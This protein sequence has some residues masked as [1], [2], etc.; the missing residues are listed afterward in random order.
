MHSTKEPLTLC[1]LA[2]L[3]ALASAA[4]IRAAE[5]E[6]LSNLKLPDT[7]V[8]VAQPV[9]GGTF[10]PP[11]GSPLNDLPAFCRVAGVI[12]PTSD[13]HIQFEVWLPMKGWNSKYRGVGNGGFAGQIPYE[14]LADSVRRNYASAGTDDG[15]EA[16]GLDGS[17]A[18]HHPE[19][20]VDFGYRAV[21]LTAQN[22]K[23]VI[24]AFYDSPPQHSYFD[25][26]SDGG[27]EALMEAQRFPADF[28]GILAGAPA[29]YWSHLLSGG[30]SATHALYADPEAY[31]SQLKLP[32]LHRAALAACDAQDGV[33]DGVITDPR[34]CH[35]DPSVLL[36]HGEESR[37]CLTAPQV[38]SVKAI[39]AGGHDSKGRQIFPGFMPGSEES[40]ELWV[41]GQAPG[42]SLGTGFVSGYFR[43]M[44]LEDP[45]WNP[46]AADIDKSVAAA[47]KKTARI[48]NSDDASI[49]DF[50]ARGGKLI[51]YHGWNDAA[52]SPLNTISYYE[53]VLAS[54][55]NQNAKNSVRLYVAPGVNHCVGGAGPSWFGQLGT[56]TAKGSEHGLYDA[57]ETWVEKGDA[58]GDIVASKYENDNPKGKVQMTRPLCAYPQVPKYSGSGDPNDAANFSC[59]AP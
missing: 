58:P 23:A 35:F 37:D 13:S 9:T 38:Q 14:Q 48:L 15:H 1:S 34:N 28:D 43:Y 51:L 41:T 10:T 59:A 46:L 32:A 39:Y 45:I 53:S 18:Y 40:W 6:S 19:K 30:L 33:K 25:G 11:G 7:T 24:K 22:A 47:D 17:W 12:K 16:S 29:N 57:L 36:C 42:Q 20:V 3:L 27:R 31:I 52:I 56:K 50:L 54:M 26:C 44:V 21:H 2:T 5:C 8:K 4:P 55:A 49:R